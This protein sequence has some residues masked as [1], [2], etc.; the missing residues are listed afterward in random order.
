MEKSDILSNYERQV[1][2]NQFCILS[3]LHENDE[4]DYLTKNYKMK[5]DIISNGYTG[6]YHEIFD[7][8]KEEISPE[9]CN[10]TSEILNMYRRINY[11]IETLSE[12]EKENLD[13][14]RISFEGFDANNDSH[15]GYLNFMIENLDKWQE[16]KG[17]YINSHSIA[18]LR[19][20]RSM[21]EKFKSFSIG[22][23]NLSAAELQELIN[24]A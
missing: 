2:A 9:I 24:V 5:Q 13:L 17:K 7:V 10:E 14:E 16:Y 6:E 4:S 19:K 11:S 8:S 18:S 23:N 3:K 12:E 15:Y 20:Y 22:I 1:L 21:L